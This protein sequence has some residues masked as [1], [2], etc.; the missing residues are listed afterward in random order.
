MVA[1]ASGGGSFYAPAHSSSI[2]SHPTL[3]DPVDDL[4]WDWA[5]EDDS[6]GG[7]SAAAADDAGAGREGRVREVT[8]GGEAA[9][10]SSEVAGLH[11]WSTEAFASALQKGGWIGD[12]N[13][14]DPDSCLEGL[15]TASRTSPASRPTGGAELLEPLERVSHFP[16]ASD[17]SGTPEE[18]VFLH[19]LSDVTGGG[20]G[21]GDA[22]GI[23]GVDSEIVVTDTLSPATAFHRDDEGG[24]GSFP[25]AGDAPLSARGAGGREE[26]PVLTCPMSTLPLL[27]LR[28]TPP[29]P[30]DAGGP[31][32]DEADASSSQQHDGFLVSVGGVGG[33]GLGSHSVVDQQYLTAAVGVPL[34]E[35]MVAYRQ[36][37]YEEAVDKLLPLRSVLHHIGGSHAQRDIVSLTL[38]AAATQSRQL[39]L[40]RA[41]L[42]ER[43]TR[44][45]NNGLPMYHLSSIL[46]G[47]GEHRLAGHMR[48][49]AKRHGLGEERVGRPQL[50][51]M[52]R[53][54]ESWYE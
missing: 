49:R 33:F 15:S 44:R 10:S 1:P 50:S 46:Y 16:V 7:A 43:I 18:D 38:E 3:P 29:P 37:R 52:T 42:R 53:S 13:S 41:L 2:P 40:A 4:D 31:S 27:P 32:T 6:G 11:K 25:L 51:R 14:A 47:T 23:V 22:V 5:W 34:A 8:S 35:G 9:A 36:G 30:P 48:D 17:L 26:R 21:A 39:L 45:P 24:I 19:P 54:D 12:G 28:T 20:G